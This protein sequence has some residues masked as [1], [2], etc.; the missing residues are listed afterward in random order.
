MF[1]TK[2][3]TD[4]PIEIKPIYIQIVRDNQTILTETHVHYI[5]HYVTYEED[6][7]EI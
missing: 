6:L 4:L 1:T 7:N 3:K 5:L 2:I